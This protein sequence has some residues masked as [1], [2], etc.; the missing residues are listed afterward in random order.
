MDF[1]QPALCSA[2]AYIYTQIMLY[3]PLLVI[4]YGVRR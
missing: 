4:M 3:Q 2:I 1:L